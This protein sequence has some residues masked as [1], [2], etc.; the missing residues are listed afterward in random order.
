MSV[1]LF[2]ATKLLNQQSNFFRVPTV[3]EAMGRLLVSEDCVL[4]VRS[5]VK[6]SK[7]EGLLTALHIAVFDLTLLFCLLNK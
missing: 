1:A 4:M 3:R 7:P 6:G 5:G 2:L